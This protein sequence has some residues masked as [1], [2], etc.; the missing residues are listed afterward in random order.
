MFLVKKSVAHDP[1]VAGTFDVAGESSHADEFA[2]LAA[3][4]L[5]MGDFQEAEGLLQQGLDLDPVNLRCLA[6]RAV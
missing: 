2:S 5:E 3:Q 6:Y 4:E 1:F